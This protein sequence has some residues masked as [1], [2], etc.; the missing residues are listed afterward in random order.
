MTNKKAIERLN[1][2]FK[3]TQLAIELHHFDIEKAY[4]WMITSNEL[5]FGNKPYEL[6]LIGSSDNLV[7]FLEERL[8]NS[9]GNARK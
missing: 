6:C 4:T 7:Q 1:D 5:F 3:C 8:G 2:I 9:N